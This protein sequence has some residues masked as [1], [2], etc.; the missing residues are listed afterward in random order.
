[1]KNIV[2]FGA[3]SEIARGIIRIFAAEGSR[4]YLFSRDPKR[5]E[6]FCADLKVRFGSEV[7]YSAFDFR[8][9]NDHEKYINEALAFLGSIDLV[10]VAHGI[11]PDQKEYEHSASRILDSLNVNLSSALS[12]LTLV[13]NYMEER[14]RGTIVALSSVAGERGRKSNYVYGSAKAALS[15]FMSGLRGRLRKSNVSVVTVKLGPVKTPMTAHL[16]QS[17]LF[18]EPSVVAKDIVK[19]IRA[20]KGVVYIPSYWRVIMLVINIIPERLFHLLKI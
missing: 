2:V 10:V 8:D 15:V 17:R 4:F 3:N 18:A 7:A 6:I 9:I 16:E 14:G 13:S 5:L 12:F 20:G 19:A 1:M 11:L